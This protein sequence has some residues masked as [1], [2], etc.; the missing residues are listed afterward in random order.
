MF[1]KKKIL[2]T[3][4]SQ[5]IYGITI[6]RFGFKKK[7]ESK[8]RNLLIIKLDAIGDYILFRNFLEE[9]RV[10]CLYKDYRITFLGNSAVRD[11][12]ETLDK[13]FVDEFI[14]INRKDFFKN[15]FNVL[16]IAN[17]IYNKFNTTIHAT[18]S[19]EFIGDLLV[20][21]SGSETRIGFY[22][23]C[24]NISEK[25]KNKTDKWYTKLIDINKKIN[26]EFYKNK[27]FFSQILNKSL[28]IKKPFIEIKNIPTDTQITLPD[29]FVVLFPGSS[30]DSKQWPADNFRSIGKYII[31]TYNQNI[32]ICG[33]KADN[34]SADI[35]N[36]DGDKKIF[37]L[38]GK[39]SL[40]QLILVISK[41][42]LVI[43]N[44]T[45][46][47]HIGAA[48][49]IPTII[50]SRF[51]HYLRF[52]PYPPEISDKIFCLLPNIF[53]NISEDELVEKFKLGSDVDISLISVSDVKEA[54]TKTNI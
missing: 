52:V 46:G 35:I 1:K 25:E 28:A 6:L 42:K 45:S 14:W 49:G 34:A 51:N 40:T 37:D 12:A 9:I 48:L 8:G 17:L 5:L 20:K 44:D 32:V 41:A 36:I 21:L 13:G 19:R 30:I 4:I 16:R 22:G 33:S 53:N 47:A 15:P 11:I 24:N 10:S 18:H 26:F 31:N 23:D 7:F 29:N 50:L 3:Y 54:I 38:T 39:T 27:Y 2:K 43:S